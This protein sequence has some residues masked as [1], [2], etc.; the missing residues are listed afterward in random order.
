MARMAQHIAAALAAAL[1]SA[2]ITA[3]LAASGEIKD[4]KK[5]EWGFAGPFGGYDADAL[6]RGFQVYRQVC[7]SCHGAKL[8]FF[9]N[10]GDQGGPFH[11]DRCPEGFP[12]STDCADPNENP[13]IKALAAE[14]QVSDGPDD[15]GDMF[16]RSGLP[17]DRLPAPY[18]NEQ[19]ARLGNG[20]ALPP[21]LSLIVKARKDGADYIYSLLTGFEAPPA[22]V[23][24]ATGQYYNPYFAGDM[25]Q[26]LKE[27]YRNEEGHAAKGVEVPEGGVLA[28][29]PP[30]TDGKVD[31][32]DAATPET[33]EQYAA[34]VVEFLAWASEPKMEQRKKLGFMSIAYLL[35]L[36]GILYWSYKAIW[37]KVEH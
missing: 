30:L 20:G 29:A 37:A 24:V 16:L 4:Y 25:S 8:V 22:T 1:V 36:A 19:M 15:S 3:G 5:V 21:D 26:L 7:S 31:Y 18:P 33:V 11:L 9:R 23:T 10:L 27:E 34:D 32:A 13:I 14:Y 17:S 6:Q 35:I 28:M 12:E 2:P